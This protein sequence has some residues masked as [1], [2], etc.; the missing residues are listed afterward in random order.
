MDHHDILLIVGWAFLIG[1][2]THRVLGYILLPL[3]LTV[4]WLGTVV[5]KD[6]T[7]QQRYRA[8]FITASKSSRKQFFSRFSRDKSPSAKSW[9]KFASSS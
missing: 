2:F 8:R 7:D 6:P 4:C 9:K 3:A 1:H 5:L